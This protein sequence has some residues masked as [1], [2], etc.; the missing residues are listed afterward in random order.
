[1]QAAVHAVRNISAEAV[2]GMASHEVKCEVGVRVGLDLVAG[3]VVEWNPAAS[4]EF[5]S[6][7]VGG[8]AHRTRVKRDSITVGGPK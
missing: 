2:R 5:A 6:A 1:M 8:P 3:G 7:R 4:G